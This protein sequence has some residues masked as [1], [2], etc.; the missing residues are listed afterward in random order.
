[1]AWIGSVL[2][3]SASLLLAQ[4]RLVYMPNSKRIAECAKCKRTMRIIAKNVCTTCYRENFQAKA[5]CAK[6]T[7]LRVVRCNG[8]CGACYESHRLSMCSEKALAKKQ[9]HKQY[10]SRPENKAKS[11]ER[12]RKRCESAEYKRRL[13]KDHYAWRLAKYGLTLEAYERDASNGCHICASRDSLQVDHCHDTGLYRGILCGKCNKAL[14]L[15]ND[16]LN[17]LK[18]AVNYLSKKVDTCLKSL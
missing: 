4:L 3:G 1:M 17:S 6:C 13:R 10:R 8:M 11:L 7:K 18:S 16:N 9:Y 5:E 2:R 14:G 15:F 12:S